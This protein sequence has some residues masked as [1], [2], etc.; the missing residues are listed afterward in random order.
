MTFEEMIRSNDD[1][2]NGSDVED[3]EGAPMFSV[4]LPVDVRSEKVQDPKPNHPKIIGEGNDCLHGVR[5]SSDVWA[6][7]AARQQESAPLTPVDDDNSPDRDSKNP[8]LGGSFTTNWR[9][10]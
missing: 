7:W 3:R 6:Q 4:V 1:S 5:W 9:C 2:M 10:D 8:Q